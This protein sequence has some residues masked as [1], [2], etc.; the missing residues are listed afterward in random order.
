MEGTV[1]VRRARPHEI[2][3]LLL[4]ESATWPEDQAFTREH[5]ECQFGVFPDGIYLA[6]IDGKPVGSGVFEIM[7]YDL[8]NPI[9]TWYEAT[10]NG[11]LRESHNPAGDTMYGVS[12]S[13]IPTSPAVRVGSRMLREAQAIV[14]EKGLAKLALGARVPGFCDFDGT[15]EEY[16]A[17]RTSR[18]YYLDPE[19]NFYVRNGFRVVKPLP[20]YFEDP[21]SRGYG[22]LIV[23]TPE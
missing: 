1:V 5:F 2:D 15:I 12:L 10:D 23:W 3:K 11:F 4:V 18:G 16:L 17:F 7:Y 22:V 8:D 20:G 13:V 6:E 9:P 21:E 19:L 14:K